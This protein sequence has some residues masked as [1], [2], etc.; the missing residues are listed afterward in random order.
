MAVRDT[1]SEKGM[2]QKEGPWKTPLWPPCD[3]GGWKEGK[4]GQMCEDQ[5]QSVKT[6][7]A[8]PI[9]MLLS[10]YI[11]SIEIDQHHAENGLE[12]QITSFLGH[13]LLGTSLQL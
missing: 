5:N 9:K 2:R 7:Q 1:S 10:A 12:P 6:L 11:I 4:A 8:Q 3:L 13:C